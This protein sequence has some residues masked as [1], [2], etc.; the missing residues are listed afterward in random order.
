M[1][2]NSDF[3][4]QMTKYW[5]KINPSGKLELEIRKRIHKAEYN[6]FIE[7]SIDKDCKPKDCAKQLRIMVLKEI[8][9]N[10]I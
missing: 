7:N 2:T 10:Y 8:N 3:W 4:K 9:P 5:N 6:E 1:I